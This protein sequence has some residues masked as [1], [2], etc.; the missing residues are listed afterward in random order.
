MS[1]HLLAW[2]A[3]SAFAANQSIASFELGRFFL[4]AGLIFLLATRLVPYALFALVIG[5]LAATQYYLSTE[6]PLGICLI[7]RAVNHTVSCWLLPIVGLWGLCGV[8]D[9]SDF[10]AQEVGHVFN[11]TFEF[12]ALFVLPIL[13]NRVWPTSTQKDETSSSL[14][15]QKTEGLLYMAAGFGGGLIEFYFLW[16]RDFSK[17]WADPTFM[18]PQGDFGHMFTALSWGFFG[19]YGFLSATQ[20]Q[21]TSF[22]VVGAAMFYGVIM[23]THAV[24]TLGESGKDTDVWLLMHRVTAGLFVFGSL[25]RLVGKKID[26][27]CTF[28]LAASYFTCAAKGICHAIASH[29]VMGHAAVV[30]LV[31]LAVAAMVIQVWL[32]NRLAER[33]IAETE[34]KDMEVEACRC[35]R[36]EEIETSRLCNDKQETAEIVL[37]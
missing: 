35:C 2:G 23:S 5:A 8:W 4:G 22:H 25:I 30:S 19:L 3:A 21:H 34:N 6:W 32:L 24:G 27:A 26:A 20:G 1:V 29:F 14:W 31:P 10:F 9:A 15:L 28:F 7:L 13:A 17:M 37:L 18:P 36:D 11:A 16:V 33:C 12:V